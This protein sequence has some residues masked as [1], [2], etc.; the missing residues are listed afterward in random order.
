MWSQAEMGNCQVPVISG[1]VVDITV[2]R[3]FGE[4]EKV[5][6]GADED[7][8]EMGW[9][10]HLLWDRSSAELGPSWEG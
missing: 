2:K 5:L 7:A 10:M 1:Q 4:E 6:E 3:S 9:R 8:S